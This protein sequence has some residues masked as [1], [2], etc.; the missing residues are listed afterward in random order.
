MHLEL[1]LYLLFEVSCTS[2]VPAKGDGDTHEAEGS[3]IVDG[4]AISMCY[5][6]PYPHTGSMAYARKTFESPLLRS[7][8]SPFTLSMQLK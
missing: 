6:R 4:I 2:L 8:T 7:E 5:V 3:L 1:D